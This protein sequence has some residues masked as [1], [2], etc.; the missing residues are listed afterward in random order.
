MQEPGK[1]RGQ[2]SPL[3]PKDTTRDAGAWQTLRPAF[4]LPAYRTADRVRYLLG[5]SH[6]HLMRQVLLPEQQHLLLCLLLVQQI[7]VATLVGQPRDMGLL[8]G[9]HLPRWPPSPLHLQHA[10]ETHLHGQLLLGGLLLGGLWAQ[11]QAAHLHPLQ[12]TAGCSM[13]GRC[14]LGATSLQAPCR[15]IQPRGR[16]ADDE[17]GRSAAPP[18]GWQ[19]VNNAGSTGK[20][21]R[22][23]HL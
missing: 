23:L 5:T 7:H 6:D 8:I 10:V 19:L 14:A 21:G 17:A 9:Q 13:S 20:D 1:R 18:G 12:I 16:G 11:A 22:L 15:T 2:P 3:P 4:S